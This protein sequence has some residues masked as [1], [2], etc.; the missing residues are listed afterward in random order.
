MTY[1]IVCHSVGH[2]SP[3]VKVDITR[4]YLLAVG[5]TLVTNQTTGQINC[6]V[7]QRCEE[8]PGRGGGTTQ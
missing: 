6:L 8:V 1:V 4:Y 2:G 7:H 3:Y 5:D